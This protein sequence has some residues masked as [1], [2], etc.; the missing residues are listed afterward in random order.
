MIQKEE[1]INIMPPFFIPPILQNDVQVDVCDQTSKLINQKI[2]SQINSSVKNTIEGLNSSSTNIRS[3]ILSALGSVDQA[4]GIGVDQINISIDS[5]NNS[6]KTLNKVL[7]FL[8]DLVKTG[9]LVDTIKTLIS[10]IILSHIPPNQ[11]Q[12][13]TYY[14]N[15][16][17]YFFIITLFVSPI[18]SILFLFL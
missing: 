7:V 10:I 6:T 16:I 12:N 4:L 9:S 5:I 15:A 17:F 13:V 11:L 1:F 2:S 3:E 8:Q 18:L 14:T